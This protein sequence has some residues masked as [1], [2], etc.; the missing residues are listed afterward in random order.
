[1]IEKRQAVKILPPIRRVLCPGEAAVIA[2]L[3][4]RDKKRSET[5]RLQLNNML[6]PVAYGQNH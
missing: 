1:M 4:H 6:V 2:I 5:Y 3:E